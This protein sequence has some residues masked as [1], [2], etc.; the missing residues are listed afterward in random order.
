MR[1]LRLVLVLM[2]AA[3]SALPVEAAGAGAASGDRKAVEATF[4]KTQAAL[5]AGKGA[6]ALTHLSRTTL[7]RL[8]MVRAE[9]AKGEPKKNNVGLT[10]SE[11][12]AILGL[13]RQMPPARLARMNLG[14]LATHALKEGWLGP[15][16][17]RQSRIDAVTVNG[18][19]AEARLLVNGRPQLLPAFFVREGKG[20]KIDLTNAFDLGDQMIRLAAFS[21]RQSEEQAVERIL[22]GLGR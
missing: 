1:W 13:R 15:N 21:Q 17:I 3:P 4:T 19:Q 16:I 11:R 6:T 12:F 10:P 20:W 5:A 7:D 2:L 9:A 18:D 8:E 22:E 14:E